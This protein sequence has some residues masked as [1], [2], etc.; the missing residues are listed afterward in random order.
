MSIK[1]VVAV[2]N[3]KI[4]R[5]IA[6]MDT[7]DVLTTIRRK[8]AVLDAIINYNPHVVV[9]SRELSGKIEM[10]DVIRRCRS[11]KEKC[12]VVF[13]YGEIDTEYKYFSYFL[14][15]QGIYNILTGAVDA[16]RLEDVIERVYTLE[17]IVGYQLN[18]ENGPKKSVLDPTP[19]TSPTLVEPAP[20]KELEVLFVEKIV[21]RETIQTT[22]LGNV[23]IGVSSLFPHGGSTHT[24]LELAAYLHRL[25]KDSG[26]LTDQ[27]TYDRIKGF[28][29]L[30]ENNG[31]ITLEGIPIYTDEAQIMNSHR[32]VIRDM[33][34]LTDHNASC[35]LK[36]NLKLLVCGT[37]I[38]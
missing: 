12:R 4:E 35:F 36:A 5:F 32:T 16:E 18:Q 8:E 27:Q 24:A 20:E 34:R 23:I 15:Q 3:K 2:G 6:Q 25:K 26:L 22:V 7:I 17:D 30:K 14:V 19:N 37:P 13:I 28:Y 11:L 33:G 10:T 21:E 29:M 9:L 1:V 31:L 38:P